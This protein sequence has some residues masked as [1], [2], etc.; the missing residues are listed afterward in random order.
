MVEPTTPTV[1]FTVSG[2]ALTLA[3]AA[4]FAHS[5]A[6]RAVAYAFTVEHN[7]ADAAAAR[8][9]AN[10][11]DALADE[12]AGSPLSLALRILVRHLRDEADRSDRF[13]ARLATRAARSDAA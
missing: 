9:L 6:I 5:D 13:A 7:R 11:Y 2:E 1:T 4:Y 10:A 8:E 12:F 3:E